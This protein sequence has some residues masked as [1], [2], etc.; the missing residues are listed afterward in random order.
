MD[1]VR[2][3]GGFQT[4]EVFH[5]VASE[6]DIYVLADLALFIENAIPECGMSLAKRREGVA[7][8]IEIG[9][10]RDLRVSTGEGFEMSAEV[11]NY[12]HI[13]RVLVSCAFV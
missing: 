12:R 8:R 4:I 5:V 2:T 6:E 9:I 13:L 10:Q 1:L 3:D 11:Y 7:D